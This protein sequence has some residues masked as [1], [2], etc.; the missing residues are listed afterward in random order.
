MVDMT[1][2]FADL[3]INKVTTSHVPRS[4]TPPVMIFDRLQYAK[5]LCF[6]IL[7]A[8]KNWRCRRPGN[9]ARSQQ[10]GYNAKRF[11]G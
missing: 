10:L 8:I 7:Q 11:I 2:V 5:T 9:E 6:C 3:S 4:S 1:R